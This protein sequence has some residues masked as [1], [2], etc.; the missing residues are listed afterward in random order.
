MFKIRYLVNI[1]ICSKVIQRILLSVQKNVIR[2]I[3][4]YVHLQYV[5]NLCDLQLMLKFSVLKV[6]LFKSDWRQW[7][8]YYAKYLNTNPLGRLLCGNPESEDFQVN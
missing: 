4:Q 7:I 3:L 8:L 2:L 6:R 5:Y 1:T